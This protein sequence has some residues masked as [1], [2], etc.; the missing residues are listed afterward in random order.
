MDKKIFMRLSVKDLLFAVLPMG[1]L[2]VVAVVF[3]YN[4]I[5]PAPPDPSPLPY[6]SADVE[7]L[8]KPGAHSNVPEY[9]EIADGAGTVRFLAAIV[10]ALRPAWR[11]SRCDPVS[12][13]RAE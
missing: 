6:S 8:L 10:A 3:A 13:L 1:A 11:A 7:R 12:A 5:E 2:F 9:D 4:Y